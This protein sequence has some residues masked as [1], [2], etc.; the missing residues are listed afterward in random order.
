VAINIYKTNE[1]RDRVKQILEYKSSEKKQQE[2]QA[3]TSAVRRSQ[4]AAPLL[5]AYSEIEDQYLRVSVLRAL[6]PLDFDKRD[7]AFRSLLLGYIY[8]HERICGI[9][10]QTPTG[11][12]TFETELDSMNEYVYIYT[13]D[14]DSIRP[15]THRYS[16]Q[17]DWIK[18][19]FTQ[20]AMLIDPLL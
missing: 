10:I 5:A 2:I 15:K 6:W 12:L 13:Y 8:D 16:N 14:S 17:E 1:S 19:F 20:A 7:D 18:N 4:G 3:H 11:R 9:K